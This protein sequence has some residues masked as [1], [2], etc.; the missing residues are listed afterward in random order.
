MQ[1][2]DRLG[3][4]REGGHR[5]L[6]WE[7][8]IAGQAPALGHLAMH[9]QQPSRTGALVQIIDILG[10][11]QPFARPFGIELRQCLVRRV[12]LDLAETRPPRIVELMHQR[13]V[14][15]VGFGRR[16]VLDPVAFPQPVSAS[17]GGEA[18]VGADPGAGQGDAARN[19]VD[20]LTLAHP[21]VES[22][23]LRIAGNHIDT[24]VSENDDRTMS[25][26]YHHPIGIRP[27]DIDHMGHVN[28]S[29]YLKWV[30]E[31]VI[32]YWESLA[33]P[34]AVARHLWVALK[35][36]I[37]Y[38][39]PTFVDDKVVADVIAEKGEGAKALSTP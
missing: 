26:A 22:A 15:A 6:P 1:S 29:V 36:E 25:Q 18:A 23:I 7:A 33:P 30:Q 5:P 16:H 4:N 38:R 31:A 17:K 24:Y 12:G 39:R 8:V 13:R 3:T 20:G 2:L 28:N 34:D 19:P 27:D 10:E 14:A 32:R 37:S 35:H 11:D 21:V 9:V